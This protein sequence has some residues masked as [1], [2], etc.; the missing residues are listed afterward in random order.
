MV[1]GC[2]VWCMGVHVVCGCGVD[3]CVCLCVEVVCV[4]VG[5]MWVV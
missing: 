3:V 4:L 5:G 1:C 2:D